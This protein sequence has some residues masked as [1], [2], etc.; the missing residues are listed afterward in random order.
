MLLIRPK[1]SCQSCGWPLVTDKYHSPSR[2]MIDQCARTR[3]LLVI[4]IDIWSIS[5]G[6]K[7]KNF[8]SVTD[9]ELWISWKFSFHWPEKQEI[10][11]ISLGCI[12]Y[13][14]TNL[15]N[16]LLMQR[17][18]QCC[19]YLLTVCSSVW[20]SKRAW[21]PLLKGR[22]ESRQES[23][24]AEAFC[25]KQTRSRL[26]CRQCYHSWESAIHWIIA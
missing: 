19:K 2:T 18:C 13:R 16:F 10:K 5:R 21:C 4:D 6:R 9:S 22:H 26:I 3:D 15:I 23:V 24:D 8:R 14:D 7:G 11:E 17:K 1:T 25:K 12:P 20:T